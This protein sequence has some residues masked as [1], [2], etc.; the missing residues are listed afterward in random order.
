[1]MSSSHSGEA[2]HVET[3]TSILGKIEAPPDV[4]R[5]GPHLPIDPDSALAMQRSGREPTALHNN[6]SGKHVGMLA[7]ARLLD[8]PLDGY[9]D[10][11]HPAQRAIHRALAEILELD[12]GAL[13]SGIDGCSAPAYAVPLRSMAMGYARLTAGAGAPA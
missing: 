6:C 12:E 7:L 8:A 1:V 10:P 5:C 9:L 11:Q 3:V 13:R 4:L 2:R